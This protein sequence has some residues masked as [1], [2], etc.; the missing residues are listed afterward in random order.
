MCTSDPNDLQATDRVRRALCA[1][2]SLL[3]A[4]EAR[5]PAYHERPA[6]ARLVEERMVCLVFDIELSLQ[7]EVPHLEALLKRQPSEV[8]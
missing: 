5:W 3:A 1:C 6:E 7:H 2:K 8:A 4:I